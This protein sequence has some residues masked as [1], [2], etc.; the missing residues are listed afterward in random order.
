MIFISLLPCL[1]VNSSVCVC[2]KT[3][4]LHSCAADRLWNTLWNSQLCFLF[5]ELEK[6]ETTLETGY[7]PGGMNRILH[8]L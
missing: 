1:K 6:L 8:A 2:A 7:G 5:A 3:V 4:Q